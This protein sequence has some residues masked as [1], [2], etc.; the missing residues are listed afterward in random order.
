[1]AFSSLHVQEDYAYVVSSNYNNLLIIDVSIFGFPD[2]VT[3]SDS[4]LGPTGISIR[5]IFV[6]GDYAYVVDDNNEFKILM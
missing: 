1:M 3:V 2:L 6:Q 5:D 4:P